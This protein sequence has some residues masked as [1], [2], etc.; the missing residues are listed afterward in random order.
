[1]VI[2]KENPKGI[3]AIIHYLQ[4][5]V[6]SLPWGNLITVYPRCYRT[7]RNEN[8]VIEHYFSNGDYENV[9][10][11][12]GN[13]CFFVQTENDEREDNIHYSTTV[14]MFFI[15]DL[16][17]IKPLISHRADSEVRTDVLNQIKKT[18]VYG[19]NVV[20]VDSVITGISN[21]FNGLR[22]KS[23]DDVQPYHCFKIRLNI[24]YDPNKGIC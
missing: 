14:E 8:D 15:L 3:D 5:G 7:Y 18:N 19:S 21:V 10:T 13:K 11:A 6:D 16:I 1:M 24:T 20:S 22:Y 2:V 23:N 4:K 12:E 9:I 17:Q